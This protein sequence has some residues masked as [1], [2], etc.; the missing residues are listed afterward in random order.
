MSNGEMQPWVHQVQDSPLDITS[1][2]QVMEV[3]EP[4]FQHIPIF[5]QKAC[6][7]L[8]FLCHQSMDLLK[9]DEMNMIS[10]SHS[11]ESR[12]FPLVGEPTR[13]D[14]NPFIQAELVDVSRV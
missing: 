9:R 14:R 7:H 2:M 1:L 12:V 5:C 13:H 11:N 10:R 4:K 8:P 3:M 6:C